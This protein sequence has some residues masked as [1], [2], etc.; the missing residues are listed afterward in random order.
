MQ[1]YEIIIVIA[2]V[3]FVF[4]IFGIRIYKIIKKKPIDECECCKKSAKK[5]I[6]KYHRMNK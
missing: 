2:I 4:S 5:L 1:Y 6:K 3:T